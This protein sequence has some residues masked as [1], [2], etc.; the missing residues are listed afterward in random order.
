MYAQRVDAMKRVIIDPSGKDFT[1]N[2]FSSTR[3]LL[4]KYMR[5]LTIKHDLTGFK[6]NI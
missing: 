3:G 4:T 1:V 5:L 2:V 6:S